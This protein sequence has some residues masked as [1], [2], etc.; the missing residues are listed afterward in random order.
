MR[1]L[2]IVVLV[3][4]PERLPPSPAYCPSVL[5]LIAIV[6][7]AAEAGTLKTKRGVLRGGGVT[8]ASEAQVGR[9]PDSFVAVLAPTSLLLHLLLVFSFF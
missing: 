6:K 1:R 4:R 7:R 9:G 8:G 2:I 3:T 5:L